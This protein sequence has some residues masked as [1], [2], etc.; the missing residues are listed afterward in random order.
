[1]FFFFLGAFAGLKRGYLNTIIH[2]KAAYAIVPLAAGVMWASAHYNIQYGPLYSPLSLILVGA[3]CVIS[4]IVDRL[5]IAAMLSYIGR[6]SLIFYVS[7][8][9]ALFVAIGLAK[10]IGMSDRNAI[11]AFA[12]VGAVSCGIALVELSRA[13]PVAN[14]LFELPKRKRHAAT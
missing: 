11:S 12:I 14:L 7:H 2:S 5:P 9:A 13:V 10:Q 6:Y 8:Y 1:M 4:K 3:V